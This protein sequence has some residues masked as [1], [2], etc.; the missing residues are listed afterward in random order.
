VADHVTFRFSGGEQFMVDLRA[1]KDQ[2]QSQVRDQAMMTAQRVVSLVANEWPEGDM[3]YRLRAY[4]ERE[5]THTFA[6]RVHS[7]SPISNMYEFGNK[8]NIRP[9][10]PFRTIYIKS[11]RSGGSGFRRITNH[12]AMPKHPV[13][14][15]TSVAER[16]RFAINCRRI[17]EQ[18]VPAI[19]PGTPDVTGSL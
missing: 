14:V 6:F 16:A 18:P 9:A 17:L 12:G 8:G 2:L 3:R 5:T 4:L 13:F 7:P 19:G 15:A 11:L 10:A 1:W